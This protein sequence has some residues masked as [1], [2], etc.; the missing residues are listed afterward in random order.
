MTETL[1]MADIYTESLLNNG[2]TPDGRPKA[3]IRSSPDGSDLYGVI[4]E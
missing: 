3:Y 1:L 4:P 2:S